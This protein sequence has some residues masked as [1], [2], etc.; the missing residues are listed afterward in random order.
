MAMNNPLKPILTL[1]VPVAFASFLVAGCQQSS[2]PATKPTTDVST[3]IQAELPME[4][5]PPVAAIQA[6]STSPATED[7]TKHEAQVAGI[8][9]VDQP[10]FNQAYTT[11]KPSAKPKV[12]AEDAYQQEKPTLMGLK[13]GTAKDTV[14][15]RF[16]KAKHQF[17]MEEDNIEVFDF[18]DFSVG[19]NPKG[20]LEFVDVHSVDI[21]PGLH[22]LRLGQSVQEALHILGK[23]DTNSTYVLAYKAQGTLLKLDIDPHDNKIQSIKLFG[24]N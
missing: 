19:F 8:T 23:P 6:P 14:L 2:A 7:T 24:N 17:T 20:T 4:T 9:K 11:P 1:C 12:K 5:T 22:G 10:D 3:H 18:T 21:D 13:L 16:G 15:E